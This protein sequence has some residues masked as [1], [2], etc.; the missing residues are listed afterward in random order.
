VDRIIGEINGN[1]KGPLLIFIGGVHGN[2]AQ[3]LIALENIFTQFKGNTENLRG[4]AVA[5]RGNLEAIRQNIR[6]VT[7]DLNRIW[8]V[9]HFKR[10]VD[11]Q[12]AEVFE[13]QAIRQIVDKELEGEY[14]EAFLIDLHTTSAPT[15][16]FLV[17]TKKAENQEF[18]RKFNVPYVTGLTGYLDGTMLSWM[19]EKG[20]NG[21][22]FEAGQHHSKTSMIK[23]EAFVRLSMYYSGF[24]PKLTEEEVKELHNLLEDE[25]MPKHNH[26]E[27]IERYKIDEE[28]EFVMEE[29][30]ANFQRIY[31]GEVLA[32]NKHGDILS[33]LNANIFMPLYQEQ[34]NDGYFIIEPF[35]GVKEEIEEAKARQSAGV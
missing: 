7:F 23:H 8:D 10:A 24:C 13:L 21:M 31:K 18:A 15:I 19:C 4:R 20:Y 14:T 3:G 22:A 29:G 35:V 28:E 5:I 2:E 26:F 32:T 16:P 27:L 9:K 25:L 6:F 1:G 12:A 11:V 34:G 30:F 33:D 17:T